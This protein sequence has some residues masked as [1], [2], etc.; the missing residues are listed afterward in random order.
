MS[1]TKTMQ[2]VSQMQADIHEDTG[3]NQAYL[4]VRQA[5]PEYVKL[6]SNHRGWSHMHTV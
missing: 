3:Q 6:A 2:T 5:N 1:L 4:N